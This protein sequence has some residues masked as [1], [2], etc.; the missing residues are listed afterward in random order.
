MFYCPQDDPTPCVSVLSA[1]PS[2]FCHCTEEQHHSPH[3]D[4]ERIELNQTS[5]S[6]HPAAACLLR[7]GQQ[8]IYR[9]QRQQCSGSLTQTL[10]ELSSSSA[11]QHRSCASACHTL[12]QL[13]GERPSY[14]VC[15]TV[16]EHCTEKQACMHSHVHFR[17]YSYILSGDKTSGSLGAGRDVITGV[18]ADCSG[19]SVRFMPFV[20]VCKRSHQSR[21]PCH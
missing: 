13:S 4:K 16:T 18:P 8:N 20:S 17:D 11:R 7:R 10:M 6:A 5:F 3:S 14:H 21:Y 9:E 19:A 1:S 2:F 15:W 12:R